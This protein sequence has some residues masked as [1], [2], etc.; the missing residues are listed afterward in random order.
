MNKM[1]LSLILYTLITLWG[2]F[3]LAEGEA[4]VEVHH[5]RP[6]DLPYR[7]RRKAWGISAE[8]S[9]I[10]YLPVRYDSII[11]EAY[12]ENMFDNHPVPITQLEIG[13][14]WNNPIGSFILCATYG[15]GQV[16]G[17]L[18]G[19]DRNL[20]ISK[21]GGE[22]SVVL[23]NIWDEPRIAPY[24]SAAMFRFDLEE[25]NPF[26]EIQGD[27]NTIFGYRIGI[28][29]QLNLLEPQ[30]SRDAYIG[31]GLENTYFD[32]FVAKNGDSQHPDDPSFATDFDLGMGIRLEF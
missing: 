20:I 9:K 18:L 26:Y 12:Y 2:S 30:I 5:P 19:N 11:D 13:L 16:Y 3:L 28:L 15:R 21:Y 27:T 32:L 22:A 14:K 10:D 23:D 8:V 31:W 6:V 25:R 29:F 4:L 17:T 24:F 1:N 7:E